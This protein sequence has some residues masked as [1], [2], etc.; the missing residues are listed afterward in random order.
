MDIA[1]WDWDRA[2]LEENYNDLNDL[3]LFIKKYKK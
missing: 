1:W 2:T 3:S